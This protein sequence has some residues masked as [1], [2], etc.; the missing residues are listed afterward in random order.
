MRLAYKDT[1]F[2]ILLVS[3][4]ILFLK[5]LLLFIYYMLEIRKQVDPEDCLV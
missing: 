3:S 4:W 5:I 1:L 2:F